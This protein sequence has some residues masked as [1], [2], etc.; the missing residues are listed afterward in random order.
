VRGARVLAATK[1]KYNGEFDAEVRPHGLGRL[2]FA[3]GD[4]YE[5]AWREGAFHGE[6]TYAFSDGS[7]VTCKSWVND[8][9]TG[10]TEISTRAGDRFVGQFSSARNEPFGRGQMWFSTG[11][12]ITCADMES[13]GGLRRIAAKHVPPSWA[14]FS[15]RAG[16]ARVWIMSHKD[17]VGLAFGEGD[18]LAGKDV[19]AAHQQLQFSLASRPAVTWVEAA[20]TPPRPIALRGLDVAEDALRAVFKSEA[21]CV[22]G[23]IGPLVSREQCPVRFAADLCKAP[24]ALWVGKGVPREFGAQLA[25][26]VVGAH[27]PA[28][29]VVGVQS[30]AW[31]ASDEAYAVGEVLKCRPKRVVVLH[32]GGGST[33]QFSASV[34]AVAETLVNS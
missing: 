32:V 19:L 31:S 14:L 13:G 29:L 23:L 18:A 12:T 30:G 27:E 20:A 22:L 24:A 8:N 4:A 9:V 26:V 10:A 2:D 16:A 1:S 21:D 17:C 34:A 25:D 3:N 7:Q 15:P 28:C 6:G 11:A 5:G 33:A